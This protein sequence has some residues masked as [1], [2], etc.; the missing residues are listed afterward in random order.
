LEGEDPEAILKYKFA[1]M[2]PEKA[3][4]FQFEAVTVLYLDVGPV[5]ERSWN[6]MQIWV[7]SGGGVFERIVI[8]DWTV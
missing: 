2:P 7:S 4:Q 5:E 3:G 1:G 8:G 6:L